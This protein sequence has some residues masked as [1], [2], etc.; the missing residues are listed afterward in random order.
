MAYNAYV[1]HITHLIEPRLPRTKKAT[2]GRDDYGFMLAHKWE[3][4]K[5]FGLVEDWFQAGHNIS[6]E[7]E[8]KF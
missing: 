3:N 5:L 8:F 4:E 1:Q 6:F 2:D 7:Q